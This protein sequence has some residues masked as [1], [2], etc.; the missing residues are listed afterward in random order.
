ML[1]RY[2]RMTQFSHGIH[3][4]MGVCL[5]R[6]QTTSFGMTLLFVDVFLYIIKNKI[7]LMEQAK[8]EKWNEKTW[9]KPRKKLRV[10]NSP[11]IDVNGQI[12]FSYFLSS[13]A[14]VESSIQYDFGQHWINLHQKIHNYLPMYWYNY[15]R[16][17]ICRFITASILLFAQVPGSG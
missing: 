8:R 14:N 6:E 13:V 11:A 17:F 15:R 3:T 2:G 7:L 9:K 5:R 12:L 4:F 10:K 16:H 1:T